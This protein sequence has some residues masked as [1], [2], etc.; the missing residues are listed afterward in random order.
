MQPLALKNPPQEWI[1]LFENSFGVVYQSNTDRKFWLVFR[2]E[3]IGFNVLCFYKFKRLVDAIDLPTLLEDASKAA[4]LEIISMC[5][6]ERCL[7]LSITEIIA[8]KELLAGTQVMLELNSIL[9][10]RLYSV[11]AYV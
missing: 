5:D 7:V 1:S 9:Y 4:D 8:L 11:P 6:C 2:D 10:E 3:P